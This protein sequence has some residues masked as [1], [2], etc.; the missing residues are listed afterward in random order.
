MSFHVLKERER[1]QNVK[2]WKM[3]VQSV[4][5]YCFSLSNMQICGVFVAVVVVAS[6]AYCCRYLISAFYY[7]T[8][9]TDSTLT[10][11]WKVIK[12][13]VSKHSCPLIFFF[14]K[15]M[16]VKALWKYFLVTYF[17][18]LREKSTGTDLKSSQK[19]EKRNLNLNL[20]WTL[21]FQLKN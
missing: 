20:K 12:E 5:K 9:E 10:F 19:K 17:G 11:F 3:H 21:K 8:I 13:G 6:A 7:P 1:L 14:A 4:Q 18:S 2:R 16:S 15:I